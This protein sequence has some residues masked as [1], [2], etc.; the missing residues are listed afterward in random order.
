MNLAYL[1]LRVVISYLVKHFEFTYDGPVPETSGM[2][3]ALKNKL[4]IKFHTREWMA[5]KII[6]LA[7][8]RV[9]AF[10]S[11]MYLKQVELFPGLVR[12]SRI[13]E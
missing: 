12:L 4:L 9:D 3:V 7:S 6:V 10:Q 2:I 13:M 8:Q 5:V 11:L 1:E